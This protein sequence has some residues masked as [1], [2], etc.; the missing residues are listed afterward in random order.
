MPRVVVICANIVEFVEHEIKS[1]AERTGAATMPDVAG[2]IA[3]WSVH[4][5]RQSALE[6]EHGI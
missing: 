3:A 6:S 4:I 5:I 2:M 1:K